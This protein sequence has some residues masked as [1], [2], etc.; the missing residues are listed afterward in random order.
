[1]SPIFQAGGALPADHAT[2]VERQADRDALHAALNGEYLHVIAPRQVGKTSFLK[3]LA[4]RLDKMGWHFA[5]VDLATLM[6]FPK[7][8][9]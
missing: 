5:Y 3:R 6:D 1:M 9:W 2:Y 4:A 8:D 7:P